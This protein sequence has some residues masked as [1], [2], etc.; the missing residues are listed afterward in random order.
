MTE[1]L[2]YNDLNLSLG[3]A[4]ELWR[5]GAADRR[6]PLHTPVVASLQDDG[7][8]LVPSQRVLVLR[9]VDWASRTMRFHTDRRSPKCAAVLAHDAISVLGYHVA[10]KVQMRLSGRGAVIADGPLFDAAW[11]ESTLF[12]RRCYL[13]QGAPGSV[14]AAPTSGL[15]KAMEGV[16][17]TAS[18][19]G[20]ARENFAVLLF[21]F[22]TIDWLYLAN[23]GH[24]RAF[25]QWDDNASKWAAEWRIP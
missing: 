10:E 13:T 9:E 12:A 2:F 21:T 14:S 6:S 22:D 17:P 7:E 15:P 16:Q 18:D 5:D 24:R 25:F 4:S 23:I 8:R 1:A 11:Q 20:P 19:I 3:K